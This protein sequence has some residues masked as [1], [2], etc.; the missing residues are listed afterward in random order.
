[1][2]TK[3]YTNSTQLRGIRSL[4]T[5]KK[6]R[7]SRAFLIIGET[8]VVGCRCGSPD[9]AWAGSWASGALIVHRE[10][11]QARVVHPVPEEFCEHMLRIA[12][13]QHVR[14]ARREQIAH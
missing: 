7:L 5:T 10:A 9:A 2:V 12:P 3:Q 13:C 1:M 14:H 4:C 6:P 11:E 8:G